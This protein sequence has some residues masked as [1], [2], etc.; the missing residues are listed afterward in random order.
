MT[1]EQAIR[2]ISDLYPPDSD[3][4][5]TAVI[6]LEL[7]EQ[8]KRDCAT[9]KNEPDAVIFRLLQ[10]CR[11]KESRESREFLRRQA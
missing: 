10:L 2:E 4:T 11:E 3:Y 5:K 6:G 7:L 8:A 9:W 1:R